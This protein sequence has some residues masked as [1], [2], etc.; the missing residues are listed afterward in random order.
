MTAVTVRFFT[1]PRL[2]RWARAVVVTVHISTSLGWLG[3]DGALMALEVI[4]RST[5]DPAM[6]TGIATET[7]VIVGWVL[8]PVGFLSMVSGLLLALFS[9]R[10]L[11]CRRWV[12]ATCRIAAELAA[13]VKFVTIPHLSRRS[14]TIV[15]TVHVAMSVG[16][17]GIDGALVA[18]EVTGLFT[19]DPAVRGGIATATAVIACWVLVPVVLFALLSGLALGLS[20]HWGLM[21]H[22]WVITKCGIAAVLAAAGVVSLRAALPQILAGGGDP[23]GIRTLVGRSVALVLLFAATGLSVGKPWGRTSRGL[24]ER[25]RPTVPAQRNVQHKVARNIQ[26]QVQQK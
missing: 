17:L 13:R 26:R 20:T 21:R 25:T 10:A 16:W 23:A 5:G 6:R 2:L 24:R 7:G 18:L 9:R 14:R 12:L 19:G 15:L 1:I 8:V 11:A 4:E 3:I 22:W